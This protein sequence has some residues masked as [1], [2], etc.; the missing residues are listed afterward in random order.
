MNANR[1]TLP[2]NYSPP[3]PR[4]GTLLTMSGVHIGC[5]LQSQLHDAPGARR[6]AAAN[7]AE[8]GG[9]TLDATE[10]TELLARLAWIGVIAAIASCAVGTAVYSLWV[11]IAR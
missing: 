10:F 4:G 6:G 5:A 2:E 3:V 7:A 11:E 1:K 9:L 8:Y